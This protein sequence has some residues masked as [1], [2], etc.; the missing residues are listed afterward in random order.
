M[1][2][3]LGSYQVP[4]LHL[5]GHLLRSL[6]F[7]MEHHQVILLIVQ[8]D[9]LAAVLAV[10]G[11]VLQPE[12]DRLLL[13]VEGPLAAVAVAAVALTDEGLQRLEVNLP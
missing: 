4:R 13:C 1:V 10:A 6:T 7:T 5:P 8:G 12:A 2:H 11:H 3:Q 9:D